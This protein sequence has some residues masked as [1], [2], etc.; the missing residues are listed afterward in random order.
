M[1][2]QKGEVFEREWMPYADPA[3]EF[4][5]YRLTDP[6]YTST[7][8]GTYNRVISR[9]SALLLFAC[10]RTGS[11][12]AYRMDL[13]AGETQQLTD[14]KDLDPAS[15]A[16]LPDGRSFCYFAERTLYMASIQTLRERGVYTI[17]EGWERGSGLS[18]AA[19]GAHATFPEGR[20]E[21]SRLRTVTLAQGPA[22]TIVEAPFL[23]ADPM[24]RPQRAQ[25]LYR[26]S[27]KGLWLV[28]ADGRQNRQL[29]LTT[30]ETGPAYWAAD[31]KAIL[32]LNFPEDRSQLNAIREYSPDAESDKLVAKTSQFV[33][34]G[35]NRDTSVFV[36]ASRNAAS[37]AVLL[38]LRITR[39]E[40]TL[41]EHRSS[42][43][44]T[45]TPVFA[46]DAQRIYFQSDRHGK[47]AIYGLHV[48]RLVEKIESDT[49]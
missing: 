31:G 4:Q 42:H 22:R 40:L 27:G 10:D 2:G 3:T 35:C 7:L 43:P 19:D 37:P 38:L 34:F 23:I 45:V 13:K 32:Y 17:P 16:L 11:M 9:N 21:A 46:P 28:N 15:L 5:V 24:E 39:R 6:A 47:P 44:E 29:K 49:A 1:A 26:E 8:P 18:V 30:G 12:Q 48:E 36:G 41:C 33:S 25:F 14:R 20:R